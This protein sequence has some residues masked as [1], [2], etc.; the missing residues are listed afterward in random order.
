M[1]I[2]VMFSNKDVGGGP[3]NIIVGDYPVSLEPIQGDKQASESV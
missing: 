1:N 3:T 2:S